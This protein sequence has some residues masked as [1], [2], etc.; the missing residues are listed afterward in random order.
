MH[1]L[2]FSVPLF[3]AYAL[4]FGCADHTFSK[5]LQGLAV[6]TTESLGYKPITL[7]GSRKQ[8]AEDEPPS[9]LP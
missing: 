1:V 9:N 8:N 7:G 6:G 2:Q 5:Y 3:D 4:D